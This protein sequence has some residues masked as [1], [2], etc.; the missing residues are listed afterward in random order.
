MNSTTMT[1]K[2]KQL[3]T[4]KGYKN[5]S[6]IITD[7]ATNKAA[8]VDPAWELDTVLK[9]LEYLNADLKAILLTHSHSDHTNL[10]G[11]LSERFSPEVYISKKEMG[12]NNFV[13]PNLRLL[14]DLDEIELGNTV[15]TAILSP[16]HTAG[17]LCYLLSNSLFSGDTIFIEGCGM[18]TPDGGD[19]E[20]LFE[21]IQ[22]IKRIVNPEVAVYPG[23]SYG[24]KPGYPLS[25]LCRE[26]IY[27]LFE[28]K[29]MFISFRCRGN[30]PNLL[31]FK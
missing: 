12:Y 24:K 15:I 1:Y 14:N 22:R 6:Y 4:E 9:A 10:V 13:C 20:Q 28:E 8:I 17:S 23:H 11:P 2:V 31:S 19:P 27:F 16:G 21:T 30:Q 25:Y 3:K 5:Y 18:C 7:I 26:N 29:E